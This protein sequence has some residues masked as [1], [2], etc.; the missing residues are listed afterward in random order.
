MGKAA[1]DQELRRALEQARAKTAC[2]AAM[3]HEIRTPLNGIIGLTDLALATPLS[4]EQR[5]YLEAIKDSSDSLLGLINKVLDW[6]KMDSGKLVLEK[7]AF[8]LREML[9]THLVP[10]GVRA[11]QKGLELAC[12]I[13]PHVPEE[14]LGDRERLRQVLSNLIGNAIKF[15]ERGDIFL[16]VDAD[17]NS[18]DCATLH[19]V[20][21][22]TGIGIPH[23]KQRS[24]FDAFSQADEAT[25]RE[26]GGTGLGLTISAGL[27]HLM[28]GPIWVESEPGQGSSFHFTADFELQQT[29][30][31]RLK[32]LTAS[33]FRDTRALVVD[34]NFISR[35]ILQALLLYWQMKPTPA[36]DGPGALAV[37]RV[38]QEQG[39][40]FALI[41]LDG[42]M[43]RTDPLDFA[44][45]LRQCSGHNHA[46]IILMTS[47][48]H[49]ADS[50]RDP[51]SGI[52]ACVMKPVKHADLIE[53]MR[54]ALSLEPA[55]GE[56][57]VRL[58]GVGRK[59]LL[60]ED[61]P[62]NQM[63]AVQMLEKR[64]HAVAVVADGREAVAALA[65]G[66]YD[67]ILMDVQMP[68]MDGLEATAVIRAGEQIS[69]GH[70]PIVAMTAQA[71]A[72]D[73]ANCLASGMDACITKPIDPA[74]L[75]SA[76]ETY[77]AQ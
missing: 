29:A 66:R 57:L 7:R 5:Q 40:P 30:Q 50:Y 2:L 33:E 51:D 11:Q 59:I 27:V 55:R 52:T 15:T 68:E 21:S 17:L 44:R 10:L 48:G 41:L 9:G 23:E 1:T 56:G 43:P 54:K 18:T 77:T 12:N 6:A 37:C 76:V 34:D 61:H 22:D 3:S 32:G 26:Y 69:G 72:E 42:T 31:S 28:G 58:A 8:G 53:A 71:S 74:E 70:I 47:A 20:V 46:S 60:A 73:R 75:F 19:F 63:V 4:Q 38:A 65:K 49:L 67:L 25:A 45:Q 14:L 64:G 36:E 16:H 13:L 24:I 39:K 35:H 62:V